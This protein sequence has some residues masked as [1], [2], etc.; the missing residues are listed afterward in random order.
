MSEPRASPMGPDE[1]A[2]YEIRLEGHLDDRWAGR[3]DGLT[4]SREANGVTLLT[5]MVAD[6]A[7]L[8]GVL[9]AIRDLGL[10]LL[11]VTHAQSDRADAP[12]GKRQH[13]S[14]HSAKERQP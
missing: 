13:T 3:F 4:L 5:G 2:L 14:H 8:H 11:S 1:P 6:Q 12:D 9:R 7:A 10:P